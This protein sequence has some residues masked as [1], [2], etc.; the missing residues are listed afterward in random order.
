MKS[1]LLVGLGLA[2]LIASNAVA[3]DL[4]TKAKVPPPALYNWT[5]CY[6]GGHFD[7]RFEQQD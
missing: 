1:S 3:A 2:P 5:G 6:G 4:P 7:S